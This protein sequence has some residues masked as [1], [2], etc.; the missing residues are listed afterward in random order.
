MKKKLLSL[1][2]VAVMALGVLAGCSSSGSTEKEGEKQETEG[3][4]T[5]AAGEKYIIATDTV[6]PPFEFTNEEGNFVGIDVD[7]INAI[8]EDQGIEV[9][10]QSLGFDAALLAVQSGQADGVIAGMSITDERKQTFDFSEPYFDADVT[11]AVAA[12]SEIKSYE[13]LAGKTVAVKTATNGAAYAK[14]IADEYGFTVVEFK[15]SPTMYQDVIAGN[16]A[17]CFEDYPVM[18][19]NIQ[20]GAGLE[21]PE[22]MT[23]AG[24]QYGFAVAKGQNAELLE[25]FNAGL[26]NIIENGKFQEIVDTYTK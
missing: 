2:L 22:G 24:T 23:A 1:S 20:Q 15:D 14:S 8:A 7:I 18:A 10:I 13:D 21:M 12:G 25:K 4:G 9:E 11:M 19:Y 5:E 17:A 26:A 6:F 3:E 16:T